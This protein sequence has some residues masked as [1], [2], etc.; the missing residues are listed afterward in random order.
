MD[1]VLL[2]PTEGHVTHLALEGFAQLLLRGTRRKCHTRAP[3][4]KV[5]RTWEE[6]RISMV[7]WTGPESLSAI[8]LAENWQHTGSLSPSDGDEGCVFLLQRPRCQ[9]LHECSAREEK[10]KKWRNAEQH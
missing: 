6:R 1:T 4:T 5:R 10:Q 2:L 3:K 7:P 9:A 8:F